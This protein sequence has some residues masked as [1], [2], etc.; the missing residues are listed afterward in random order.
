MAKATAEAAAFWGEEGRDG[1][2]GR[3]FAADAA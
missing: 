1:T 2:L 3:Y